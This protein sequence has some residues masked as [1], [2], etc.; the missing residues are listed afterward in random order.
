[1][2]RNQEPSRRR[3]VAASRSEAA[4][5]SI[6]SPHVSHIEAPAAPPVAADPARRRM[7]SAAR[8]VQRR[9]AWVSAVRGPPGHVGSIARGAP[10]VRR[11]WIRA[12]GRRLWSRR[13]EPGRALRRHGA[14][15]VDQRRRRELLSVARAG[16]PGTRGT[17][18][19]S[20]HSSSRLP[21]LIHASRVRPFGPSP[22]SDP[23]AGSRR[24]LQET[25]FQ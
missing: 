24:G 16:R 12:A 9:R 25:Q 4:G 19:R 20:L 23:L 15:R 10:H 7:R 3:G 17:L 5:R 1:M 21:G 22:P 2:I 6:E 11:H 14:H 8:S 13:A 18:H